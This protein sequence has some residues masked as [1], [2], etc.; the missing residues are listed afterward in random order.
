MENNRV[1][2]KIVKKEL[3]RAEQ[4]DKECKLLAKLGIKMA[5]SDEDDWADSGPC[6]EF[7]LVFVCLRLYWMHTTNYYHE[8]TEEVTEL[9]DALDASDHGMSPR[10]PSAA[11]WHQCWHW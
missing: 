10:M 9:A 6:W 4:R 7:E 3:S 5:D 1:N 11:A 2:F 8:Q